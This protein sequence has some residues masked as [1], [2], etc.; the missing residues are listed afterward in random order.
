MKR[1]I[2]L[3]ALISIIS[4]FLSILNIVNANSDT[5]R[6]V[7]TLTSST[8][9]INVGDEIE[10]NIVISSITGF[11]GI[12][13]FNAKN[14]YDSSILEYVEVE[15]KNGWTVRSPKNSSKI[16]LGA[17]KDYGAG[18]II[19]VLKFKALK[20]SS[21]VSVKLTQLDA[22]SKDG[23]NDVYYDDGNVNSPEITF[24]I[25]ANEVISTTNTQTSNTTSS[26][27]STTNIA[28]S[29]TSVA[30]TPTTNSASNNKTTAS[31]VNNKTENTQTENTQ[32]TD[33]EENNT[34]ENDE[35]TNEQLE[36]E[37]VVPEIT[38]NEPINTILE[39]TET[40]PK[41]N[42]SNEYIIL[43]ILIIIIIL[44]LIILYNK[45]KVKKTK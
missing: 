34:E 40:T 10:V 29:A 7:F 8:K 35:A 5:N 43:V 38:N 37:D 16:I 32:T 9:E 3:L 1:T 27:S 23:E 28:T 18:T 19:G 25:S 26:T 15:G 44:C 12:D 17:D 21:S 42:K 33:I 45:Y 4:T 22:S 41:I 13:L 24:K 6:A 31:T 11:D 2:K 14:V 39:P 30:T 36:I 20:A